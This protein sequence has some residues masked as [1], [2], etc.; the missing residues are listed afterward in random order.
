MSREGEGEKKKKL[1]SKHQ[2]PAVT[3]DPLA[4]LVSEN[5]RLGRSLR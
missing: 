2:L 5:E 1:A 3:S 4:K